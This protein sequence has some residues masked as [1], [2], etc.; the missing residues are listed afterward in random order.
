[1][2]C[3]RDNYRDILRA[4]E[5]Y[6][7]VLDHPELYQDNKRNMAVAQQKIRAYQRHLHTWD[8]SAIYRH[9]EAEEYLATH[10]RPTDAEIAAALEANTF[11]TARADQEKYDYYRATYARWQ[12]LTNHQRA[13]QENPEFA[14][15]P[16]YSKQEETLLALAKEAMHAKHTAEYLG[17]LEEDRLN[18][19]YPESNEELVG[20]L[21]YLAAPQPLLGYQ[22]HT[23]GERFNAKAHNPNEK[24][25]YDQAV[26]ALENGITHMRPSERIGY[27]GSRAETQQPTTPVKTAGLPP[28]SGAFDPE[29]V[30]LPTPQPTTG[31]AKSGSLPAPK[32][33]TM[34]PPQKKLPT[35]KPAPEMTKA[36]IA[37][38]A[39][40]VEADEAPTKK[41]GKPEIPQLPARPDLNTIRSQQ[42]S[43]LLGE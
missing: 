2:R 24:A 23:L 14:K 41:A 20:M 31:K 17:S 36:E 42:R 30:S 19:R 13:A 18:P 27:R 7:D 16:E 3:L 9:K 35:A 29:T 37:R 12:E 43:K 6:K 26:E 4:R 21:D 22:G 39:S 38:L 32:L 5:A 11:S 10:T 28:L 34:T 25:V 40:I 8:L 1:M 15:T 33:P